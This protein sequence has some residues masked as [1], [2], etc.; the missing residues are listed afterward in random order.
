MI[1][2]QLS[3]LVSSRVDHV[4]SVSMYCSAINVF[5]SHACVGVCVCSYLTYMHVTIYVIITMMI[6]VYTAHNETT[7]CNFFPD[8]YVLTHHVCH[9]IIIIFVYT[10]S[11]YV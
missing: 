11:L 9:S 10:Q 4:F 8:V 1:L 3:L 6:N 5:V 2:S 7:S